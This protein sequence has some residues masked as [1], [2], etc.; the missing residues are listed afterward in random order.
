MVDGVAMQQRP[1][2]LRAHRMQPTSLAR[3]AAAAIGARSLH[4]SKSSVAAKRA[5]RRN[6]ALP[7]LL[8]SGLLLALIYLALY[9]LFAVPVISHDEVQ[10]AIAGM[11]P[12]L[13]TLFWTT[14]FPELVQWL[15]QISWLNP[16]AT[17]EG[18][19]NLVLILLVLAWIVN[20]VA[21][22]I[23]KRVERSWLSA[24]SEFYF[25]WLTMLLTT[26]FGLIFFF[27]PVVNS[28]M[29]RDMLLYA[30]YGR[31]VVFYHINPY[32][33][34]PSIYPNDPLYG[35]LTSTGG[36]AGLPSAVS[37][38]PVWLDCSLLVTLFAR[39][40]IGQ[41]LVGFRLIGLMAHLI[42]TLLL[43]TLLSKIKPEV[44]ISSTL[45][46]GW[47]PLV[48]VL[49]VSQMH[50]DIVLV[51]CLLLA[52]LFFERDSLL[53][54][55]VFVLLAVLINILFLPLLPLCLCLI[56]QKLRFIHPGLR[57]LW[58]VGMLA[59]TGLIL[60]LSYAP[61]WDRWGLEGLR[62]ALAQTFWQPGAINSLD[63]ALLKLPV[64]LP[65]P[66]LWAMVPG[67]WAIGALI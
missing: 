22:G 35:I 21:V 18:R 31:M 16:T 43:W 38:G 10:Q 58:Y 8:L 41:I 40:N 47:N 65:A 23:G 7:G 9:P 6:F 15:S 64:Q 5:A 48:L 46:Y 53:L 24:R 67:H 54:C 56:G 3:T 61:Y 25:F 59:I 27:A 33:V 36:K 49:G 20:L 34:L 57:W 13:P 29:S 37:Y 55:W 4:A 1:Q 42:N 30:L 51:L 26:L 39:Q 32:A 11:F 2:H 50:L 63:A 45:L 66:V 17:G 14:A 52:I 28:A 19:A 62:T 12:W 44:R 60:V